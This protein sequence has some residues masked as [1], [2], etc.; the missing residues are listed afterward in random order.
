MASSQ[1]LRA[2]YS[3]G[4]KEGWLGQNSTS[5]IVLLHNDR[6]VDGEGDDPF[7]DQQQAQDDRTLSY[8]PERNADS[9]QQWRALL[10]RTGAEVRRQRTLLIKERRELILTITL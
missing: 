9:L 1:R 4:I 7:R 5:G 6:E 3:S 8:E 10:E 2:I